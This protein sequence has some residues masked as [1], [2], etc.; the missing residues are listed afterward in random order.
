[1]KTLSIL[2]ITKRSPLSVAGVLVEVE[3]V[4]VVE[5]N[6]AVLV[7]GEVVTEIV[8]V[9]TDRVTTDAA[10]ETEAAEAEATVSLLAWGVGIVSEILL[11]A[12][13]EGTNRDTLASITLVCGLIGNR[14]DGFAVS[15]TAVVRSV[16]NRLG[17]VAGALAVAA[18]TVAGALAVSSALAVAAIT[19]AGIFAVAADFVAAITVASVLAVAAVTVAGVFAV[20]ADTVAA[21]TV[22]SVLAVAAVTVA[23]VFAVAA[24]T[25]AGALAVAAVT[26]GFAV[27][28]TLLSLDSTDAS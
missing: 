5:S 1:M 28:K 24:D 27:V 9:G 25:V 19:V 3:T 6:T 10:S 26:V 11:V 12:S 7:E 8:T 23:S 15:T 14:F 18:V 2:N 22:A 4:G 16:G 20:A 21:I 13:V 17:L